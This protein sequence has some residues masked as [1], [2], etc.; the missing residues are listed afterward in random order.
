MAG[1]LYFHFP[2]FPNSVAWTVLF[3]SS[4]CCSKF[5][6][7]SSKSVSN[8]TRLS[9]RQNLKNSNQ[10]KAPYSYTEKEA[11]KHSLS[12]I[13]LHTLHQ[14]FSFLEKSSYHSCIK[15][16][17]EIL[18]NFFSQVNSYRELKIQALAPFAFDAIYSYTEQH[19]NGFNTI[20]E[21][22]LVARC[23]YRNFRGG[24]QTNSLW[25]NPSVIVSYDGRILLKNQRQQLLNT[26]CWETE[27]NL[28]PPYPVC[29]LLTALL[30]KFIKM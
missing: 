19:N 10:I 13:I 30:Y 8:E 4:S 27:G 1:I 18:Y 22:N 28:L 6:L 14:H 20:D 17:T 21:L 25:I 24:N 9:W 5:S 26:C 11:I 23:N 3:T 12:C 29:M 16:P 15:I 2:L 7:S